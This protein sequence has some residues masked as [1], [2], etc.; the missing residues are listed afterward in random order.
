MENATT[1][2]PGS[3]ILIAMDKFRGT[4]S[5]LEL[6][7]TVSD[8]V[9][10]LGHVPDVQ[11]MSDGGEGF[12]EAF[13]GDHF[14]VN[15]SGPLGESV[16][17][18]ITLRVTD[19][20]T[21]AIIESADAVGR[22]YLVEPTGNEALAASS[23]GVGELIL[24]AVDL[25]ASTVLVGLGG[26][27]T[28][29]GGLGCYEVLRE[30]E[31]LSVTLIG[32]T[33]VTARFSGARRY[34]RQKGVREEDLGLVDEGLEKIR[35]RYL[36][37]TGV[38]VE[39]IDRTGAAGGIPGALAA[40]GGSLVD[41]LEA[42]ANAV[43]LRTRIGRADLVITGEGRFDA[44]SLEGKVTA[45]LAAMINSATPL[46]LVCGSV[47]SFAVDELTNQFDNV[48]TVSLTDRVGD[49]EA[50]QHVLGALRRVVLEELTDT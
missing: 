4:A 1:L 8:A 33:D 28:S 44:G 41:G 21:I 11:P 7:D 16:C 38:D 40:L 48:R 22:Q 14:N 18:G 49:E 30:R 2:E 26:S 24:A 34:A 17:A 12:R 46:L 23:A 50:T 29:D 36:A 9:L 35:R 25:G 42:V 37:E 45:G 19:T 15:V 10:E 47:E 43:E 27:A 3:R 31:G 13:E 39:T 20:G 32:A 6:C 5:A